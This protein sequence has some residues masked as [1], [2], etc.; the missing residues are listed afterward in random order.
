MR[1]ISRVP[2]RE[3]GS[4]AG[5]TGSTRSTTTI[6]DDILDFCLTIVIA[7]C[8]M[9]FM[10]FSSSLQFNIYKR[11]TS[12]GWGHDTPERNDLLGGELWLGGQEDGQLNVHKVPVI[13]GPE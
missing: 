6:V 12:L 5:R 3:R 9:V 8:F 2:G 1:E 11:G 13:T 7:R 4:W 10:Y